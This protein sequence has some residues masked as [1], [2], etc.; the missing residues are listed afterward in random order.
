MSPL[1]VVSADWQVRVVSEGVRQ[2]V[3]LSN[4]TVQALAITST[5]QSA[6]Q[7]TIRR[8]KGRGDAAG[9]PI[10]GY[11]SVESA[12]TVFSPPCLPGLAPLEGAMPGVM[13]LCEDC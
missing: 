12:L 4:S 6:P 7:S 11:D 5:A 8:G 9:S 10:S 13:G 3:E 2:A 1:P